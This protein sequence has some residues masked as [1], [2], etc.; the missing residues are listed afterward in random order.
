M[1]VM[2]VVNAS[3]LLTDEEVQATIAP[4]QTQLDRDFMPAWQ[5]RV[6]ESQIRVAFAGMRDIPQ[7]SSDCWPIFLNRHAN[8]EGALGWHDDDPSQNIR[9]YSRVF[10]GDCIQLGLNWHVT[11]SHEALELIG[12]PDIRRVWRMPDGEL[13]AYEMCDAVEADDQAYSIG[14]FAASNFV[15]P[16]YFRRSARGPF[17]FRHTLH[18]PCPTLTPGGY[19]SVT[20]NGRWKQVTMDRHGMMGRRAAMSGHRRQLRARIPEDQLRIEP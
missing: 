16:N 13:A 15:L 7:L 6:S 20:K 19:M 2:Y 17:D 11:L 10:V 3:P 18:G 1:K 4:L 12:D 14:D 8:E 5:G 9:V